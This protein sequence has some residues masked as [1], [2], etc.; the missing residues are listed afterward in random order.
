MELVQ[1]DLLFLALFVGCWLP[2]L[3]FASIGEDAARVGWM[4]VQ[5]RNTASCVNES[6]QAN[7]GRLF[8]LSLAWT[9][10]ARRERSAAHLGVGK[11]HN[12]N[13]TRGSLGSLPSVSCVEVW[14]C[15]GSLVLVAPLH[16]FV[17]VGG[18]FSGVSTHPLLF[19]LY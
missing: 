8:V 19:R 3:H 14:C 1:A 17:V 13:V 5:P 6:Q 11:T 10:L 4:R 9:I 12:A 18:L 2:S 7:V 16:V 15:K